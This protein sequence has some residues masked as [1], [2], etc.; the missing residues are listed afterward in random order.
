MLVR[1][2]PRMGDLRHAL[3]DKGLPAEAW[4]DSHDE[5]DVHQGEPLVQA[6]DGG[7]GIDGYPCL[8]SSAVDLGDGCMDIAV[9]LDMDGD[10]IAS[11]ISEGVDIA[12][13][14]LYH[15]V[16]VEEAVGAAADGSDG[17]GAECDVRN[18][19]PVHHIEVDPIGSGGGGA[20]DLFA[21]PGEVCRQ[22]GR[23]DERHRRVHASA[24]YYRFLRR[25]WTMRPSMAERWSATSMPSWVRDRR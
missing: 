16:G 25:P 12:D 7:L 24:R 1:P 3:G 23:G 21:K 2:L 15:Q 18:E 8:Q 22:Y 6:L 9:G 14:V 20:G 17:L 11:G 19:H 4:M 10:R 13:G 5:D